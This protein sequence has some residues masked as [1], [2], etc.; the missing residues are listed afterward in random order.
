MSIT[1][2]KAIT[3][4]RTRARE[5]GMVFRVQ[6]KRIG[7]VQAY[8]LVKRETGELIKSDLTVLSTYKEAKAGSFELLASQNN[9]ESEDDKKQRLLIEKRDEIAAKMSNC[10]SSVIRKEADDRIYASLDDPSRLLCRDS[11]VRK[12]AKK[13]DKKYNINITSLDYY[14]NIFIE[15]LDNALASQTAH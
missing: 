4:L 8:E 11:V 14:N 13:L 6:E 1:K 5:L 2:E 15:T 7:G 9:C 3:Q 10:I 12:A